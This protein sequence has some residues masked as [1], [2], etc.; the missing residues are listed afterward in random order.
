MDVKSE[1]LGVERTLYTESWLEIFG[2]IDGYLSEF[3]RGDEE[4][5]WK[6]QREKEGGK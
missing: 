4:K 6:R 3:F 5:Y 1:Y 2:E